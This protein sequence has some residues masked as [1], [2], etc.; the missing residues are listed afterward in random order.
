MNMCKEC[1]SEITHNKKRLLCT[2]CLRKYNRENYDFKKEVYAANR[3]A[4]IFQ[5]KKRK[6]YNKNRRLKR[7]V[8]PEIRFCVVCKK[9]FK[10][11]HAIKCTCTEECRSIHQRNLARQNYHNK[12]EKH[13][14][15]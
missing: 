15:D 12:K 6:L 5:D 7:K 9:Q 8:Q 14:R 10:T 3:K 13:G 2:D 11:S 4:K 1:N